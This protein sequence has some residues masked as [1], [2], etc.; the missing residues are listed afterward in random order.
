MNIDGVTSRRAFVQVELVTLIIV[1][2]LAVAVLTVAAQ[3]HRHRAR[4]AGSIANLQKFASGITSFGADHEDR[5][6]SFSW[7][8]GGGNTGRDGLVYSNPSTDVQAT[9][10]EAVEIIR[11]LSGRRDVARM[12]NWMPIGHHYL[13]MLD[14][15]GHPLLAEFV[16]SPF[17]ANRIAWQRAVRTAPPGGEDAAFRQLANRPTNGDGNTLRRWP[18]SSSY[19][20]VPASY[21]PDAARTTPERTFTTLTQDGLSHNQYNTGPAGGPGIIPLGRRRSAEVVFPDKKAMV[22]ES[23]PAASNGHRTFYAYEHALTPI[24]FSDGSASAR[25]TANANRGFRPN[26]PTSLATTTIAYTPDIW[27]PA[28]LSGRSSDNLSGRIRWTRSG[29][30][31][32]DFNGPDI[33]WMD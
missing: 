8:A 23:N 28:T 24:L 1:T 31:G 25:S 19:E 2:S 20:F 12:T 5:L 16:V 6:V 3:G 33:P 9:A 10:D 22:F 11:W 13:S 29:L 4:M 17:D 18:Y 30:R 21:S 14:H 32:R 26:A 27:E 7:R 15:M